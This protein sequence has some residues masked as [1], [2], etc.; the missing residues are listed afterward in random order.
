MDFKNIFKL[1]GAGLLL[2]TIGVGLGYYFCPEKIVTKDKIVEK[3]VIKIVHER[4][5]PTT[6]KVIERTT[7]DETKNTTE[8]KTREETLKR[9]KQFALKGGVAINPR[10]LSGKLI[11]RVGFESAIPIFQMS[12][13]VEVDINVDSPLVGVY[14][15]LPF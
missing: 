15:R 9:Q 2:L 14:L 10:N 13:G 1:I 11:P 5:D 3:E 8:T 12:A 7:T 6:G 4:F